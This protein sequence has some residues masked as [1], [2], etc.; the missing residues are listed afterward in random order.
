MKAK[1]CSAPGCSRPQWGGKFC[2]RHQALRKDKPPPKGLRKTEIKRTLRLRPLSPKRK[3]ETRKYSDL[4]KEFLD[5]HPQ[6][7]VFPWLPATEIHHVAGRENSRLNDT[8]KW[9][10]VSRQGHDKIHN[11]PEWAYE[12]GYLLLKNAK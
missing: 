6:C 4:R 1:P 10:A 5:D 8:S 7:A 9:L 2:D 12:N 11:N 3:K